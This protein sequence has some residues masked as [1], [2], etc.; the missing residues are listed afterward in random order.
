MIR[1]SAIGYELLCCSHLSFYLVSWLRT[2]GKV[3]LQAVDSCFCFT[4]AD[5]GTNVSFI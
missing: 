2:H 1:P 3:M 4:H 5:L